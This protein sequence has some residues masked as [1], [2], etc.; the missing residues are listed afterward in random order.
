M[1]KSFGIR[2]ACPSPEGVEKV[3][4]SRVREVVYQSFTL[5]LEGGRPYDE[6]PPF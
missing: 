3:N 2:S 1:V 5:S 4:D 6:I